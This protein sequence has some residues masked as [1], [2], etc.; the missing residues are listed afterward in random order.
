MKNFIPLI[1]LLVAIGCN[2]IDLSEEIGNGNEEKPEKPVPPPS[3]GTFISI[4]DALALAFEDDLYIQGYI[5]GYVS[6]NSIKTGAKFSLPYEK[7]NTN[8]LLA[9]QPDETDPNL[10]IAVKLENSGNFATREELNLLDHP[11]FLKKFIKIDGYLGQYFSK[12]GI[13]RIFDFE[14]SENENNGEGNSTPD[15]I[16]TPD[17]S[18][19]EEYIPEGRSQRI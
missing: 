9:D 15:S 16:Q 18:D 4:K 13:T 14:L 6:G 12:N 19:E 10:C 17:I 8:M 5:V 2:K 11:E 7:R 3:D 1:L